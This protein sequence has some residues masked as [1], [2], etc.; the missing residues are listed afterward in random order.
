MADRLKK[1][2]RELGLAAAPSPFALNPKTICRRVE[3]T[4]SAEEPERRRY[5]KHKLRLAAVLTAAAMALTG[6]ALAAGPIH[7]M[8]QAALGSFTPFAQSQEGM[9]VQEGIQVKVLSALTDDLCA[10]VYLEVTDL[11]G[12]RLAQ[13]DLHGRLDL[14][15]EGETSFSQGCQIVDY[16]PA[17]KTA[18][19]CIERNSGVFF[20]GELET[21]VTLSDLRPGRH[22]VWA[23]EELTP[24]EG[25]TTN[26][27]PSQVLPSGE[28]V[29]LPNEAERELPG[30]DGITL[31]AV[32]FADDG[33]FHTLFRFPDEAILEYSHCSAIPCAQPEDSRLNPF[34]GAT[35]GES[36]RSDY[37][38]DGSYDMEEVAFEQDGKKYYD[39]SY[40]RRPGGPE[41][42]EYLD[43]LVGLCLTQEPVDAV[44]TLPVT[45]RPVETVSSPLT[46]LI[47]HNTLQELR[48]S[49]LGV[50]ITSTSP[51]YTQIWGYPLTVFLADGTSLRP[52]SGIY[53]H[54]KDGPNMARWVFDR[55][56]EVDGITGIA[57]GAW[58]IPVEQGMAGEGYWLPAWPE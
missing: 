6:T 17:T 44:W 49:P 11:T 52:R 38:Q 36:G 54:Q 47:D 23:K 18:L 56:V 35:V 50:V 26:P 7:E 4:L 22:E 42:P 41:L 55:P 13:A 8:L 10:K 15:L 32:G 51:D 28:R 14:W 20:Q 37:P 39:V 58:M 45:L 27:V 40:V 43:P 5:M 48:L 57:L 29:L 1:L 34:W 19:V 31:A 24:L 9:V 16:D 46:G 3:A 25:L 12:D 2:E 21:T 30:A 33:R 53:G